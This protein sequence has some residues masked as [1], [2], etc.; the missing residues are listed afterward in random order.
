MPADD[1]KPMLDEGDGLDALADALGD[2]QRDTQAGLD[3]DPE[4]AIVDLRGLAGSLAVEAQP[5]SPEPP[6]A[7]TEAPAQP[8]GATDTAYVASVAPRRSW[9]MPLAI[10]LG[11]GV[12]VGA[13]LFSASSPPG[14][15]AAPTAAAQ[16]VAPQYAAAPAS[17]GPVVGP[18][19]T[20]LQ[21]VA[22][23][24]PP[25]PP[26]PTVAA[27]PQPEPGAVAAARSAGP[28]RRRP[29][30]SGAAEAVLEVQPTERNPT[31][32]QPATELTPS[33]PT[34]PPEARAQ[35]QSKA[36][37]NMD[38][39]LDGALSGP[40]EPTLAAKKPASAAP[41]ELPMM[42]SREE[43]HEAM[44]VL[45][46]AIRGCAMGQ[47]G[48]ATASIIVR[49]DGRVASASV[50]GAPFA[51]SPSGRCMEGVVRRARFPRF[52]QPTFRVKFPLSIR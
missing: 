24:A 47:S 14:P 32:Q 43:V 30:A 36:H 5:G 50:A 35:A 3:E 39:L 33:K 1:G 9:A 11:A 51:G 27:A 26:A 2:A 29:A 44:A 37:R 52:K 49:S 4:A 13:V 6:R 34:P 38:Q 28:A 15:A 16:P 20:D 17:P 45:L 48:L 10:G 42:P 22:P 19:A 25:A 46:P 41:S 7:V 31:P 18:A 8:N 12:A 23:P 40:P 21:G